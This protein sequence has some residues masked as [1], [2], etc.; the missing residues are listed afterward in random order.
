M[1]ASTK[2]GFSA[3]ERAA[4]KDRAKELKATK[5]KAEAEAAV[6]AVIAEMPEPDRSIATRVHEIVTEHAPALAAKTWYGQPAWAKDGTVVL[7]FQSAAKF[8]TRYPTLGFSDAAALDDGSLWATSF[9]V[10][11]L[12]PANEK[13]ITELVISAAG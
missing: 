6:I 4:M 12:T 1:A 9:A 10:T 8:S 11:K 5:N 13:T 2:S 7:F 3:E